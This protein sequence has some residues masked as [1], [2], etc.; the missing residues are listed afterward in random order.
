MEVQ[1]AATSR[2]ASVEGTTT[3]QVVAAS[4]SPGS[5]ETRKEKRKY[6]KTLRLTS[7]QLVSRADLKS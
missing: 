7:E 2:R 4:S 1:E 5:Q 6:A 3:A